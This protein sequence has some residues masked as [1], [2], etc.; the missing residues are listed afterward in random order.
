[1]KYT[2]I[3]LIIFLI[4]C[5]GGN[6]VSAESSNVKATQSAYFDMA[7]GHK[8]FKNADGTYTEY[9][10]KGEL[11]RTN[12]PADQPHLSAS[13]YVVPLTADSY[14]IYKNYV[15]NTPVTRV[16]S[17]FASHPAGWRCQDMLTVVKKVSESTDQ[18]SGHL[19]ANQ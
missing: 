7:T 18:T 2:T 13:A 4:L 19:V 9:T 14:L 3:I 5:T 17:A 16:L 1:M 6:A 15:D 12:V 8:Y 11:F 10:R